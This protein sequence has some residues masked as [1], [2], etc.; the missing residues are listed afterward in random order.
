MRDNDKPFIL[1]RYGRWTFKIAPRDT[2]GWRQ[3]LVWMALLAPITGGFF[4]FISREPEGATFHIGL[5]LYVLAM[6]AWGAGGTMW[7]KARAEVVDIDELL[8]LRREIDAKRRGG[9]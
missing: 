6:V 4:W 1:T 7:M 3:T 2:R 8:K 5:A 9:R